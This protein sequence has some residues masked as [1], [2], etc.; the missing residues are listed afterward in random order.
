MNDKRIIK[1]RVWHKKLSKMLY[2]P[3]EFDSMLYCRD[4]EGKHVEMEFKNELCMDF[5]HNPWPPLKVKLEA[6]MTWDGR[7]YQCGEYQD[8]EFLQFTGLLDKNGKDIYEGD[9]IKGFADFSECSNGELGCFEAIYEFTDK[10]EFEGCGFYCSRADFPLDQY[11]KF[12]I[13]GNIYENPDLLK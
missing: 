7:W 13:I 5:N 1:F 12:E 11:E 10:V 2:P 3:G 4:S 9:I 6:N 8:V